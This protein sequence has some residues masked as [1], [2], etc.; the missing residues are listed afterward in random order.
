MRVSAAIALLL[1]LGFSACAPH[2][3]GSGIYFY[4]AFVEGDPNTYEKMIGGFQQL[5]QFLR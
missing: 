3:P 4:T 2:K 5:Q 1:I